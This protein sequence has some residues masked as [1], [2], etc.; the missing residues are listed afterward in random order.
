MQHCTLNSLG[1]P[2][3]G[4]LAHECVHATATLIT[5]LHA[6]CLFCIVCVTYVSVPAIIIPTVCWG[7]VSCESTKLVSCENFLIAQK[8]VS[9][10]AEF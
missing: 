2:C 1:V 9:T 7:N 5:M 10:V 4:A 8:L 6:S 3:P